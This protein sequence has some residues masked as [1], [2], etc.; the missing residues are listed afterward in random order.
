ML[1]VRGDEFI[2]LLNAD[3]KGCRLVAGEEGPQVD[4]FS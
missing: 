4:E 2:G 3:E 1:A